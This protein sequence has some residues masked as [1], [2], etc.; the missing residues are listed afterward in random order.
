VVSS[1]EGTRL[2]VPPLAGAFAPS[3][4]VVDPTSHVAR[5]SF[6]STCNRAVNKGNSNTLGEGNEPFVQNVSYSG[7]F[8]KNALE[9]CEDR[10]LAIR[11]VVDLMATAN[12]VN[13][14]CVG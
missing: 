6:V 14:P 13:E 2:R 9:L 1:F 12:S 5:S 8:R 11:M 7:R 4:S 3:S 10:V